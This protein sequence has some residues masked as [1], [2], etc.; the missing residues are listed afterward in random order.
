V[1]IGQALLS[2][3]F[4]SGIGG[5]T[6]FADNADLYQV[7]VLLPHFTI[8]WSVVGGGHSYTTFNDITTKQLYLFLF[9]TIR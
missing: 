4:F 3:K 6:V 5:Q 2:A 7:P 9:K 8:T 1:A